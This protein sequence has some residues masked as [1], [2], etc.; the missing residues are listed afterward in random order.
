VHADVTKNLEAPLWTT[1]RG[2]R[3]LRTR[4]RYKLEL[5]VVRGWFRLIPRTEA[6]EGIEPTS[7]SSFTRPI[8]DSESVRAVWSRSG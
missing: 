2:C 4:G 7:D 3:P 8:G 6:G 1:V 5:P